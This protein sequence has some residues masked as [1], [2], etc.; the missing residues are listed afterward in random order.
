M[1]WQHD[2]FHPDGKPYR[3]HELDIIRNLTAA[4]KN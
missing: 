1:L 3:P 2:I 4:N